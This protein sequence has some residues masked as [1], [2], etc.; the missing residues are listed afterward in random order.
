MV[1][2]VIASC[3]HREQWTV[4]YP[5]LQRGK[6]FPRLCMESCFGQNNKC[7]VFT[8]YIHVPKGFK[9]H[10]F[11]PVNSHGKC[12]TLQFW[13]LQP[14]P[15]HAKS[16]PQALAG[17]SW[18]KTQVKQTKQNIPLLVTPSVADKVWLKGYGVAV[19]AASSLATPL[20]A[21][22]LDRMSGKSV[23]PGQLKSTMISPSQMTWP[24][25]HFQLGPQISLA[26]PVSFQS[27]TE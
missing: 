10:Q 25:Q 4:Q 2:N 15:R 23:T 3:L 21:I 27:N 11:I 14:I 22:S 1:L 7:Y 20:M 8:M 13:D 12:T 9:K 24:Y 18:E 19:T 26:P 5:G 17:R 6:T 16:K